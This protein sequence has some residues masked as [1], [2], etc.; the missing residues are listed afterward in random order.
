MKRDIAIIG[1]SGRFPKSDNIE[2]F[3][4][5]LINE[6]ELIH[7]FSDQELIDRGVDKKQIDQKNYIKA[8]SFIEDTSSFDYPFFKYTL[9]EA[10]IMNPQT[11]MMHQLVWEALEDSGCNTDTYSKKA[12]IFLGA[13]KDLNWSLHAM[14]TNNLNVDPLSKGKLSNPNFMASLISYK[15]NFKGPCYFIDTAC[16]TSLSTTHLACRSLLLNECGIA[17][18]GGIR[19]LSDEDNG[20]NYVDGSI[21]S[22]DG[23][24]R[25]F[26]S[27]SSGTIGTD[28]AGVVILKRLE[29]AL[30]DN[31]NVYAVIKGTA[32]NNDGSEKAGYTMPSIEG[33]SECVKLAQKIAGVLPEDISYIEAHGTATKIGD[34]IEIE[35]LNLAFNND[36]NNQ[37]AIGTIKSNMG[38]AD[39]AAGVIGLIKTVLS[40]KNKIIPASLHYQQA[41]PTID[42]DGGP[43]YINNRTKDWVTEQGKPRIAGISSLGIGGTNVHVILQQGPIQQSKKVNQEY[44]LIRYSAKS[45]TALENYEDK[46][47]NYLE[48]KTVELD[49]LAYTLQQGRKQFDLAKYL[50]VK[51]KTDLI[52]ALKNKKIKENV[53]KVKNN[54]VFMFSGQGS[55]YINMGKD[56]YNSQPT[57]KKHIDD[58]LNILQEL[59]GIDY[60][61]ILFSQKD[62]GDNQINSTLYTQPILFTFEY[63]LAKF[64][65][66]LG[67]VPSYMIGH[68]L[69]EYVAATISNVF[70]LEDALKIISKRAEL[71]AKVPE[72]DML[73]VGLP[74]DQI[75]KTILENVS[76]AAIN[77]N[78]SFVI[79]GTKENIDKVKIKLEDKDILYTTLKTS[80]AFHSKMMEVIIDDFEKELQSITLIEPKIPFVSNITGKL[81]TNEEATSVKYWSNHI[82]EPVRFEKGIKTLI[83]ID[84]T[85]FIEV[86]P[87]RT[88]TTF[89]KKCQ[90]PELNNETVT[91]IRH[92]KEI[93][94][95][96]LH[97]NEFLGRLWVNGFDINWDKYYQEDKPNKISIPT[98]AFDKYDI[99]SK[100]KIDNNLLN[101]KGIDQFRKNISEAL[102]MPSWKQVPNS[103]FLKTN[104]SEANNY[105][106]FN[107][108]SSFS[109]E[110]S[111]IL[112]EDGKNVIQ[113]FQG[114]QFEILR[115]GDII[116]NPEEKNDYRSLKDHLDL[117]EFDY[118]FLIYGWGLSD[119]NIS[120]D[121]K[122][123][124]QYNLTFNRVLNTIQGLELQGIETRKKIIV[125]SDKNYNVVGTE[126]M[127]S[128][129]QQTST[130]LNVQTQEN[131]NISATS[132]DL[133][134]DNY[135][136]DEIIKEFEVESNYYK[137]AFRYGKRW[138]TCYEQ[139]EVIENH[140]YTSSFKNNGNYL[141]T[142]NLDEIEFTLAKY[143]LSEY[144]ANVFL[145]SNKAPFKWTEIEKQRYELLKQQSGNINSIHVDITNS[146]RFLQEIENIEN[147]YGQINGIIH[148]ARNTEIKDI[149]LVSGID[150]DS[151]KKHFSLRVDGFLNIKKFVK[152]KNVDFVKV[153]S[154]LSSFLGGI[155]YGAY[156][157]ASAQMDNLVLQED[158][159]WT[160]LNLDRIQENS[161]QWID[162]EE[163]LKAFKY[164]F[165]YKSIKQIIVSKRDLNN[166]VKNIDNKKTPKNDVAVNRKVL[167]TSFA[168][169]QSETESKL[170]LLFQNMFGVHGLGVEDDFFELGGDSLKAVML[171]NKLKNDFGVMLTISEIFSSKTIIEISK[172]IDQANWI[173]EDV[174]EREEI[175]TV[176]I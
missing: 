54:I 60:K 44:K 19:L 104:F 165:L 29:E 130:L 42:F 142:G 125:L 175:D 103:I 41:N 94:S 146:N 69:G 156:A 6:K 111:N 172:L 170:V 88:L 113:V 18:A 152:E 132:L 25:S 46:L 10:R 149:E 51:D 136:I 115:T 53:V 11:R 34:P 159:N 47:L 39:E 45:D 35:A 48:N 112:K 36:T 97:F 76:I 91:T 86:G 84:N 16:S 70:S 161:D 1:M 131:Q 13:N 55:Q 81:I 62:I 59:N 123:Y 73:S 22:N 12:G 50:I 64:L 134:L 14:L 61:K 109:N 139:L 71:M 166:P 37:C 78:D 43:F 5:N 65:M 27:K 126:N 100:I 141:I 124:Q 56:F 127:Q 98:Y 157:S 137:V 110:L 63:A 163:L 79:S 120:D 107:D 4:N 38:H 3:W 92:P 106:I 117:K 24:N 58:G 128:I 119:N 80:H 162:T 108:D 143:I 83:N 89:Y 148:A 95:D 67:V 171:I 164:S 57:F 151:L 144:E 121:K 147:R 28:G 135:N 140:S 21:M 114:G 150:Q 90:N 138:V 23:H 52:N 105:L 173:K 168:A 87:G 116:I 133:D 30:K 2:E 169:P 75:D 154:S 9:D 99:P 158:T 101:I 7:F 17:V 174:S 122:E 66:E 40:I 32:M 74:I 96:N 160:V 93:V 145:F 176:V 85:L 33:Q 20:Y 72:G 129:N 155:S 15:F 49:D 153:V 82:V 77:S 102:Y 26:D 8:A 68:S 167:K 31:D 118:D